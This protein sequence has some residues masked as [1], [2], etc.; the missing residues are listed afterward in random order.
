MRSG[1]D[2]ITIIAVEDLKGALQTW[3]CLELI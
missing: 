1:T 3:T 2:A